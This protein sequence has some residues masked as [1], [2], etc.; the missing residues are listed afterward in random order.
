MKRIRASIKNGRDNKGTVL[1]D[2]ILFGALIVFVI[3]PFISLILEWQIVIIKVQSIQDAV[4]L[5]A[6]ATFGA[7]E[8][9]SYGKEGLNLNFDRLT[10]DY[11]RTLS[12]NLRLDEDMNPE[13][14]SVVGNR[15]I[16]E[17]LEIFTDGF[18]ANCSE[19]TLL[20]MPSVHTII[21]FSIEPA[22]YGAALLKLTGREYFDFR[23]HIDSELPVNN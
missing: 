22:L 9:I 18:P 16:I 14:N 19:G 20:T 5:A 13:A 11:R 1:V 21:R 23:L 12:E 3:L 7:L 8:N 2:V 15:V 17:E 6:M 4:D 10:E